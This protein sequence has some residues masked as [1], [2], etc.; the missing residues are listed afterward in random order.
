MA[1]HERQ[2]QI[3]GELHRR[4][5]E[6]YQQVLSSPSWHFVLLDLLAFCDQGANGTALSGERS[7]GRYDVVAR[8]IKRA[9]GPIAIPEVKSDAA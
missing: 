8:L 3:L 7:A 5:R 1:D 9:E 6:A 4:R 2:Q